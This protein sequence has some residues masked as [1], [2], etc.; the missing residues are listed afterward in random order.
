MLQLKQLRLR[1]YGLF[2][3]QDFDFRPGLTMIGG[4]NRVGKTLLLSPLRPLFFG[5]ASGD[6]MPKGSSVEIDLRKVSA[7]G[8]GTS[9][10]IG[11]ST[12]SARPDWKLHVNRQDMA[13]HRK[14]DVRRLISKHV[15]ITEDLFD[16]TCHIAAAGRNL[17]LFA[18]T[19]AARM[20][21]LA[22]VF[23]LS[24]TYNRMQDGVDE[25]LRK[26]REDEIR[27]QVLTEQ[28]AEVPEKPDVERLKRRLAD[29]KRLKQQL[30]EWTSLNA[31]RE[32][33]R[34]LKKLRDVLKKR[35][36]KY[37]NKDALALV[38]EQLEDK[39]L[40]VRQ[41]AEAI[42]DYEVDLKLWKKAQAQ[43]KRIRD[44]LP[45]LKAIK[46]PKEG[47]QRV[48]DL[49]H[50]ME[51]LQAKIDKAKD[52]NDA[53]A[54][55][56]DA[57]KLLRTMQEPKLSAKQAPI[58]LQ[59]AKDDGAHAVRLLK[60]LQSLG[61]KDECP[62]CGTPMSKKHVAHVGSTY[63]DAI[64]K[65]RKDVYKAEMAISYWDMRELADADVKYV[66]IE[67]LQR[68]CANHQL[69]ID[70]LTKW[71]ELSVVK[72]PELPAGKKVDLAALQNKLDACNADMSLFV[73]HGRSDF[74]SER[75]LNDEIAKLKEELG[76]QD[77]TDMAALS[78]KAYKLADTNSRE[79]LQLRRYREAKAHNAS[80]QEEIA[81]LRRRVR[82]MRPL[83]VL[84]EA[85][86]RSG[87]LL[88]S[89]NDAIQHLLQEIN[90]LTP[91]LLNEKF[92][93]EIVT[94][95]RKL[96]VMIERN[97][98]VGSIRTLSTSEQRCWSLL[99][100]TAMLLILPNNMLTDTIILD[101]LEANMDAASRRRYVAEFLPYLQSI[102]SKVIVVTP[103]ISGELVL[104]PDHA[105]RVEKHNNVSSLRAL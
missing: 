94:G 30:V 26:L 18:G 61:D 54:A 66:N 15:A 22:S 104:Q 31:K 14:V 69:L 105:Y 55:K 59:K 23:N 56:K 7:E 65:A 39:R 19:P 11:A 100:A 29:H 8:K 5:L 25:Q 50:H 84:K 3:E 6:T 32:Q 91:L 97:G 9:L 27:L 87:V 68:A 98:R 37:T 34:S 4:N 75:E 70:A 101:E 95:P 1:N 10:S 53:Y 21:W 80:L 62:E 42:Q 82:A 52:S 43:I 17:P 60:K 64:E 86:G 35:Q 67:D 79:E 48:L 63:R 74:P 45:G 83:K 99:F 93:V 88:N 89:M 13:A 57:E 44:D 81:E 46:S 72:K 58:A 47:R 90:R 40:Q 16:S 49:Q 24:A 103:L 28:L 102:V 51:R 2:R 20:D 92:R 77:D 41:N 76:D 78:E 33:L 96:N 12:P 36:T 38:I 73:A 85:F 71:V